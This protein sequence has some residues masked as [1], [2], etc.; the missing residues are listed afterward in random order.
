MDST[1]KILVDSACKCLYCY[2]CRHLVC[3]PD[4]TNVSCGFCFQFASS[5]YSCGFRDS[6]SFLNMY[7][8]ICS[9]ILQTGSGFYTFCCG[10]RKVACFWSDFEQHGVLV[11]F[12]WNPKQQIIPNKNNDV[13]D[14]ATNLL[15]ACCGV[16]LH[17]T[18]RKIWPLN[19][20]ENQLMLEKSLSGSSVCINLKGIKN[21]NSARR[22]KKPR[23]I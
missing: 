4:S 14:S 21:N 8:F 10:F 23:F 20:S 6:L 9:C 17:F 5:T 22:N 13:E 2:F 7:I 11:N 18:K 15:F 3:V 1:Y 19:G 16:R 12:P